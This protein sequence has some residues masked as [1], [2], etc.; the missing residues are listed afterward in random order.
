VKTPFSMKTQMI[1]AAF[2]L[3]LLATG[4]AVT[5]AANGNH[6][7]SEADDSKQ[8]VAMTWRS[9]KPVDALHE[10]I[11]RNVKCPDFISTDGVNNR[12][13]LWLGIR[14][15]GR[16]TVKHAKSTNEKLVAYIHESLEGKFFS[17]AVAEKEFHLAIVFKRVI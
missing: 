16:I 8:E 14:P 2:V 13:E 10:W 17:E 15:D 9:A 5:L 11:R 6:R 12:V 4:S 1:R 7:R 3:A